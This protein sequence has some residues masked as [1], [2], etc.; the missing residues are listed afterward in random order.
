MSPAF[1]GIEACVFDA[2]GTLLDFNSAADQAR[3]VLGTRAEKLSDLWRSKQVQYTWLRSLMGAYVPFWQVTGEALDYALETLQI[4]DPALRS[5]LMNPRRARIL[6]ASIAPTL[7]AVI[8]E[9]H[10][11]IRTSIQ[12]QS[13][14]AIVTSGERVAGRGGERDGHWAGD[15]AALA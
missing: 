10:G 8:E 3:D 2:Y 4:D 12:G 6:V 9:R 7:R 14:G 15:F 13:G 11:T 1:D 5:R